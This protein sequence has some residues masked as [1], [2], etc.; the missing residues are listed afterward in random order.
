MLICAVASRRNWEVYTAD[1]DFDRYAK[2]LAVSLHR[3]D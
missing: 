3:S 2:C 1:W